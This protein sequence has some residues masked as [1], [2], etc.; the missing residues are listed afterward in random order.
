[1]RTVFP[2]AEREMFETADEKKVSKQRNIIN[3]YSDQMCKRKACQRFSPD[4][5]DVYK[6]YIHLDFIG[7]CQ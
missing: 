6:S 3:L 2:T 7:C 1:M 4:V 5:G